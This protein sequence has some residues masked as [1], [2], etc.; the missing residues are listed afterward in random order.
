MKKSEQLG[1]VSRRSALKG[2]AAGAAVLGAQSRR[3]VGSRAIE[4]WHV[5][6]I[7]LMLHA[8]NKYWQ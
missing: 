5:L 8:G 6:D 2:I 4:R 1:G 3:E 7:L